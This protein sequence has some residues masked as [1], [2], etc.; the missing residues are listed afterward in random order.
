VKSAVLA[1][2]GDF[3]DGKDAEDDVMLLIIERCG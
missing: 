3:L 2:F 1:Q